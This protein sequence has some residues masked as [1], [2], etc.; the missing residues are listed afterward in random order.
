MYERRQVSEQNALVDV[1]N[2]VQLFDHVGE[3]LVCC[4]LH[5]RSGGDVLEAAISSLSLS[6]SRTSPLLVLQVTCA[7]VEIRNRTW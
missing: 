4:Q 5:E 2:Q 3:A 6:N 7:G 1:V